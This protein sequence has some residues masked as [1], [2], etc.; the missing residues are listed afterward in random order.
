M[1][2]IKSEEEFKKIAR[3]RKVASDGERARV[4]YKIEQTH[5][6][7]LEV[8]S[9][10]FISATKVG[11][12]TYYKSGEIFHVMFLKDRVKE[13]KSELSDPVVQEKIKHILTVRQYNDR[14]NRKLQRLRQNINVY[15]PGG[16][17]EKK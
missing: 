4:Y 10:L 12:A 1:A 8:T 9:Q 3:A 16:Q 2:G 13:L 17:K 11:Q 15:R 6:V 7:N 14:L 5:H